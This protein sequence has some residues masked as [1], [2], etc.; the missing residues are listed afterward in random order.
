MKIYNTK[1]SMFKRY[2]IIHCIVIFFIILLQLVQFKFPIITTPPFYP[3]GGS[4]LQ[5]FAQQWDVVNP[6]HFPCDIQKGKVK[7]IY[8]GEIVLKNIADWELKEY[9]IKVDCILSESL[10]INLFSAHNEGYTF[11]LDRL[12]EEKRGLYKRTFDS[13]FEEVETIKQKSNNYLINDTHVTVTIR[14]YNNELKIYINNE[15]YETV[16]H[17]YLPL[18]SLSFKNAGHQIAILDAI[19]ITSIQKKMARSTS[20]DD[21]EEIDVFIDDFSYGLDIKKYINL[22]YF[23]LF[24]YML[25]MLVVVICD[26]LLIKIF[27]KKDMCF[28]I[29]FLS[30]SVLLILLTCFLQYNLNLQIF[31]QILACSTIIICRIVFMIHCLLV[32]TDEFPL[33][34]RGYGLLLCV[35]LILSITLYKLPIRNEIVELCLNISLMRAL[36]IF[37]A[38]WT[39]YIILIFYVTPDISKRKVI[40]YHTIIYLP[41]TFVLGASYLPIQNIN[42]LWKPLIIYSLVLTVLGKIC[43]IIKFVK[44]KWQGGLIVSLFFLG[45]I[46]T[47]WSVRVSPLENNLNW[48]FALR[49]D[50]QLWDIGRYTNLLKNHD[51]KQSEEFN[52]GVFSVHKESNAVRVVCLGTS[53]TQGSCGIAVKDVYPN[54]LEQ[55]FRKSSNK[56]CEV[57]NAGIGGYTS[58]RLLIYCRDIILQYRP[59]IITLYV[60]GNDMQMTGF[61]TDKQFYAYVKKLIEKYPIVT[62]NKK[63]VTFLSI[64]PYFANTITYEIANILFE[65]RLF[66]SLYNQIGSFKKL[67]FNPHTQFVPPSLFREVLQEF[68]NITVQNDI[69]LVLMP[70]AESTFT[71]QFK[72][73]IDIMEQ[74]ASKNNILVIDVR[75]ELFKH[76]HEEIFY[77]RVHPTPLGYEVMTDKM[78]Q[79]LI[80]AYPELFNNNF[81]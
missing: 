24:G 14:S 27:W 42:V 13:G 47:E 9:S 76:R 39:G 70:E 30:F 4:R 6:V 64:S 15:L 81:E 11:R 32:S 52:N 7:L 8:F 49:V 31:S 19:R 67:Y 51:G 68:V 23:W 63:L 75:P 56:K 53:S 55:Q 80:D 16:E 69:K 35:P 45:L 62:N 21:Y 66:F 17:I 20:S 25:L 50:C 38:F 1:F 74:V 18:Q 37:F 77:D 48:N 57:I 2:L 28:F 61:I 40:V 12:Y 46:L 34:Q 78:Y 26:F 73:Y 54:R 29:L 3:E 43:F 41:I 5:L 60:G 79:S 58:Y 22:S 44:G 33:R 10:N 71:N 36:C 72:E 65:S 59:D